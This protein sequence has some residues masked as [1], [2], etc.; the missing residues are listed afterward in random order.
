MKNIPFVI[1]EDDLV[2]AVATNMK[3]FLIHAVCLLCFTCCYSGIHG[4]KA[5]TI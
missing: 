5:A 4:D 1:S 2:Y 3:I